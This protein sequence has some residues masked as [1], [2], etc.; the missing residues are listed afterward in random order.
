MCRWPEETGVQEEAASQTQAAQAKAD[1]ELVLKEEEARAEDLLQALEEAGAV[2]R[3]SR[4]EQTR[5]WI[6][7]LQP[8]NL[9]ESLISAA[10]GTELICAGPCLLN[11]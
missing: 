10:F 8:L 4:Q 5:L 7:S 2:L 6:F 9:L 11:N 3:S 1:S